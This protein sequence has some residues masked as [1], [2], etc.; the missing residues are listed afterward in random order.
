LRRGIQ[1][2]R[3][4]IIMS[5]TFIFSGC[6]N[7]WYPP[8][9]AL[10]TRPVY[11]YGK[12]FKPTLVAGFKRT[13]G[14]N[15][16]EIAQ[17]GMAGIRIGDRYKIFQSF[18]GLNTYR[19]FYKVGAIDSNFT[20]KSV[21]GAAIE[22]EGNIVI[23]VNNV[24]FGAGI[25]MRGNSEGGSY[26]QFRKHYQDNPNLDD[27]GDPDVDASYSNYGD[28]HFILNING[29][30]DYTFILSQ[31]FFNMSDSNSP[32]YGFGISGKRIGGWFTIAPYHSKA[33]SSYQID[34]GISYRIG[35]T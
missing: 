15:E 20:N 19:G 7:Y 11:V 31:C 3:A 29:K 2:A 26:Y 17:L 35:K 10:P 12:T 5:I 27:D 25:Y 21:L 14:Q 23:P 32:V 33:S 16:G 24:N 22:W 30:L 28:L 18:I 13:I 9:N 6:I 4:I 34:T 8:A 1:L